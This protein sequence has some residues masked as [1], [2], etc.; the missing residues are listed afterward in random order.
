MR[1]LQPP[2]ST[3]S[4]EIIVKEAVDTCVKRK[5][6]SH[7]KEYMSVLPIDNQLDYLRKK[8]G[9][10][11]IA[12]EI[13]IESGRAEEAAEIYMRKGRFLKAASCSNVDVTK[14]ICFLEQARLIYSATV[15]DDQSTAE[16]SMQN[17]IRYLNMAAPCLG[18]D[19]ENL[20]DCYF[21]IGMINKN[22]Q[23]V[24]YAA[25]EFA[26][27]GNYVGVLLCNMNL[28]DVGDIASDVIVES[29][30][31]MLHF[32]GW[33]SGDKMK[34]LQAYFGIEKVVGNDGEVYFRI[35]EAKFEILLQRL[36][37][38]NVHLGDFRI[39]FNNQEEEE[40]GNRCILNVALSM[41]DKMVGEL[42]DLYQNEL[43][44]NAICLEF[45]QGISHNDCQLEHSCPTLK[46]IQDRCNVYCAIL[47]MHG[48]LRD[49][50]APIL[51]DVKF[52]EQT[53]GFV[54]LTR[55]SDQ[56]MVETCHFFYQDL[57]YF[58]QYLSSKQCSGQSLIRS[59]PDMSFLK[60]QIMWCVQKMW[61][62]AGDE[63]KFSNMNLFFEVFILSTY[64]GVRFVQYEV[65]NIREEIKQRYRSVK[66]PPKS[67]IAMLNKREFRYETFHTM[68]MDSKSWMHDE[69][70]LIESMHVLLRRALGLVLR[71]DVPLPSLTHSLIL[72]EFCLSLCLISLSR[73]NR[74]FEIHV[75]EFYIEGIHFW[76]GCYQSCFNA[77]YS[78]YDNIDCVAFMK[79]NNLVKNLVSFILDLLSGVKFDLFHQAFGDIDLLQSDLKHRADAERFLILVLVLLG[80]HRLYSDNPSS[81]R[82]ICLSLRKFARMERRAPGF[83]LQAL[84][85]ASRVNSP[86]NA[87]TVVRKILQQSGRAL[88]NTNWG[89]LHK[90]YCSDVAY[91]EKPKTVKRPPKEEK[92]PRINKEHPTVIQSP[93]DENV[94]LQK[95]HDDEDAGVEIKIN[96]SA[97]MQNEGFNYFL[98]D[99]K[100]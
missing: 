72:L 23:F 24:K 96:S 71:K 39:P 32:V 36:A 26:K 73:T 66:M 77:K 11:D 44:N 82:P 27:C 60:E 100:G 48:L 37:K 38:N 64:A 49:R 94:A 63:G 90:L 81:A 51:K 87:L 69:G 57:T 18:D 10:E 33:K 30:A 88:L 53:K 65:D 80:N 98:Q 19:P 95:K 50:M 16:N 45:L 84:D 6:L 35:N 5:D 13:L 85:S 12:L 29:L 43:R 8:P 56:E 62:Q 79:G 76:S 21:M 2:R 28:W 14:G 97:A 9:C 75:P 89:N 1:R 34:M 61:K 91:E 83:I 47:Q 40:E 58:T 20:A 41:A 42:M 99:S 92:T 78:A 3:L 55:Y 15:D 17:V 25:D 52:K 74:D 54:F 67:E 46:T 31:K 86:E 70:C 22:Q 7:V 4:V 59:L 68:F 93:I